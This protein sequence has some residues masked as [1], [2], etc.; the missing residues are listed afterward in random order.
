M[1]ISLFPQL[2]AGP[3]V[4]YKTVAEQ[5]DCRSTTAEK[6]AQGVRRFI[7]GFCKKVLLANNLAVVSDK[8]ISCQ[9]Y[10]G[11]PVGYA[12]IGAICFSL[13]IFYDFSGYSDMA[14]GLGK[15]FG[16]TFEENFN[17]PYISKSMTEFWRRWH[18]SLGQ[19]F[20]DYVYIPLGG[21]RV[22][23]IRH[24]LNLFV[25]WTLTGLWHGANF[26]F[27]VWGLIY[28]V[29]LVIE[30]YI[31][32]PEKRKHFVGKAIW[33]IVTLGVVIFAWVIFNSSGL[34]EGVQYWLAMI[35]IYYHNPIWG[36]QY[37]FIVKE[38]LVFIAAGLLFI[39]PIVPKISA[40]IKTSGRNDNIIIL[41]TFLIY[42]LGFLWAVSFLI[43][44]S[45]N[46][47]IYFN[48]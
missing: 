37:Y 16:F 2:I 35:G 19:W 17:Y 3:I 38:N 7:G 11:L 14:I 48:F 21:S 32:K 26:T 15:M 39:F 6:F 9:S 47:F 8:I 13:Q 33:Q 4:R 10:E 1:Y 30:K 43:L 45:H 31:V 22:G 20:R 41:S 28:F 23:V 18:M 25:V 36:E 34:K 24:I 46:P 29:G 42:M 12:W 40:K 44:G 5:I 27:I